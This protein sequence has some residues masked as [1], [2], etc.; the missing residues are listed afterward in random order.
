MCNIERE[1]SRIASLEYEK[2]HSGRKTALPYIEGRDAARRRPVRHLS[3]SAT[4]QPWT[5]DLAPGQR[6]GL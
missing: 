6:R 1:C 5:S 3:G 4:S 2:P